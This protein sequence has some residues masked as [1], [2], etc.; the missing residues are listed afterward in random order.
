VDN[1][2]LW[3]VADGTRAALMMMIMM[4]WAKRILSPTDSSDSSQV[5]AG[6]VVKEAGAFVAGAGAGQPGRLL[7][8]PIPRPHVAG[9]SKGAAVEAQTITAEKVERGKSEGVWLVVRLD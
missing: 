1:N 9:R 3:L 7:T 2:I 5:A 8:M 4:I 6:G